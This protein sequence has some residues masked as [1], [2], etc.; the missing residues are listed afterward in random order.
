[1]IK[2]F[3][4]FLHA[5][6][7]IA[8][9][10]VLTL[11]LAMLGGYFY[12]HSPY[13]RHYASA[14]LSHKMG[15]DVKLA[16]DISVLLRREPRIVLQQVIIGNSNWSKDPVMFSA[17]RIEVALRVPPLLK[18]TLE[19]PELIIDKPKLLLEKNAKHQANWNFSQNPAALPLKAPTPDERSEIPLIGRLAISDGIIIYRDAARKIV[20]ELHASTMT[21]KSGKDESL[22]ISGKGSLQGKTFLL[23]IIGASVLQLRNSDEPYPFTLISSIGDTHVELIGAAKDPIKM[24]E[25]DIRMKLRGQDAANLFPITG[26]VLPPTP[27][28]AVEGRLGY[29]GDHWE[30]RDFRGTMGSSDLKGT[31]AW[32]HK[33][34]PPFLKGEVVSEKL[35]MKDLAGFIGADAMPGDETRVIPDKPMDISRLTAMNAN[36]SFKGKQVKTPDLLDDFAMQVMLD[37]RV[38]KLHPLSFHIANGKIEA[39]IT[40]DARQDPPVITSETLFN[41]LSMTQLFEPLAERYGRENVTAGLIGG[42]ATLEGRGKSLREMLGSANG[43][44]GIGMEGGQLSRLL[45]EL[46]G[47]DIF[48]AT[49]LLLTGDSPVPINCLIGDFNVTSGDMQ[50][51]TMLVDTT[52]TT[53]QGEGSVNLKDESL[54]MTLHVYPKDASLLSLRSPIYIDGTLKQPSIHLDTKALATRGSIGTVLGVLLTP[55]GA[56]LAFV[57]TGLGKESQCAAYIHQLE[58]RTGG[59]IPKVGK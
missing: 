29:A 5:L 59:A 32:Y 4:Q 49:Q 17:E 9:I 8:G 35:D 23:D 10:I 6:G 38:L 19:I 44:I 2:N 53:V 1:M 46:V 58:Q 14:T 36:V 11:I 55:V 18:L 42:R 37:N 30:F 15:R 24:E 33:Q 54:N 47:L 50:T 41:R 21:G 31:V 52:V 34:H 12:V 45:L 22:H 39:N 26:I 51:R 40:I 3:K 57:E 25:V 20:S 56:L 16:G 43:T 7:I 27:P 28:Y 13:F 48:K